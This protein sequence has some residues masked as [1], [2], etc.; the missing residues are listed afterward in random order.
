M[1][2]VMTSE[3]GKELYVSGLNKLINVK[4]PSY[5][6]RSVMADT[7]E[8]DKNYPGMCKLIIEDN[9]VT[10]Q[11]TPGE[12]V[13]IPENGFIIVMDEQTAFLLLSRFYNRC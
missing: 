2:L 1:R 3:E 12:M 13:T 7:T 8:F 6:D 10:Y 9:V 5:Y 4:Y 11:S